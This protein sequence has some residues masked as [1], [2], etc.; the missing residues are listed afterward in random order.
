MNGQLQRYRA[1]AGQCS[2][3]RLQRV[4]VIRPGHDLWSMLPSCSLRFER[5]PV[6]FHCDE[7]GLERNSISLFQYVDSLLEQRQDTFDLA[8]AGTGK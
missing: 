1:A 6:L 4:P 3:C 8:R 7:N 5:S 2:R